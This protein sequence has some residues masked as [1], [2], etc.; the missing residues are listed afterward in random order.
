MRAQ[1][2]HWRQEAQVGSRMDSRV[3]NV[4]IGGCICYHSAVSEG[5]TLT[6][7]TDAETE[8]LDGLPLNMCLG[9]TAYVSADYVTTE[10]LQLPVR[11]PR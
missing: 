3:R 4:S 11:Q 6:V 10:N 1:E 7:D 8:D 9:Q 5:T 2:K